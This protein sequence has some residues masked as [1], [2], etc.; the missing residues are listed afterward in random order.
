MFNILNWYCLSIIISW[1][2]HYQQR[3]ALHTGSTRAVLSRG[4]SYRHCRAVEA[5]ARKYAFVFT[6]IIII[7]VH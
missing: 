5:T 7:L 6:Y 4:S 3:I 2:G 1:A